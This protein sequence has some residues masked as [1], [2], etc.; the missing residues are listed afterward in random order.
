MLALYTGKIPGTG[1]RDSDRPC[2]DTYLPTSGN[3]LHRLAFIPSQQSRQLLSHRHH[4][5]F[6][7]SLGKIRKFAQVQTDQFGTD[8][9]QSPRITS[10]SIT[11]RT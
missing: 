1:V 4:C 7:L 6:A 8:P 11:L 10:P 2:N 5:D 9:A 3:F